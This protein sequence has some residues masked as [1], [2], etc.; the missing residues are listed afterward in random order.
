MIRNRKGQGGSS[1]C[2]AATSS[3]VGSTTAAAA[4][5][6]SRW[7]TCRADCA[8]GCALTAP[9]CCTN[10]DAAA[11]GLASDSY[12]PP[13]PHSP[14]SSQSCL[15]FATPAVRLRSMRLCGSAL[16][17]RLWGRDGYQG[18]MVDFGS[19]SVIDHDDFCGDFSHWR[20]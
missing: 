2:T 13:P 17:V 18:T 7:R 12:S 15:I 11:A 6:T 20:V 9:C 3:D 10:A 5:S 4:R 16:A 8:T 1:A 14:A 19:F